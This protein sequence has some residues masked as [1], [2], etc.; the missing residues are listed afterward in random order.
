M[1]KFSILLFSILIVLGFITGCSSNDISSDIS[2]KIDKKTEDLN[3]LN[4]ENIVYNKFSG[5]NFKYYSGSGKGEI[6]ISFD[7]DVTKTNDGFKGHCTTYFDDGSGGE[8]V[9]YSYSDNELR[10]NLL[11]DSEIVGLKSE[12]IH[13]KDFIV[14]ENCL[15]RKTI[16]AKNLFV[17]T[18]VNFDILINDYMKFNSDGTMT[19]KEYKIGNSIVMKENYYSGTYTR[20]D[21]LITVDSY[22]L[23]TNHTGKWYLFIDDYGEIYTEV[24][25]LENNS[26]SETINSSIQNNNSIFQSSTIET[27]TKTV[28]VAVSP[29]YEPFIY[30]S[31]N[32]ELMG[33]DI[34]LIKFIAREMKCNISFK[35]VDFDALLLSV[36]KGTADIAISAIPAD[37]KRKELVDFTD[38]YVEETDDYEESKK[39]QYSIAVHKNSEIINE[40]NHQIG[41]LKESGKINELIL[42]YNID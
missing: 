8:R 18:S 34:D 37:E 15:V 29:D 30:Y 16:K 38:V 35:V 3:E 24:Y 31:N 42:K 26:A 32:D 10:I 33:F 5:T 20:N 39:I 21:N 28:T 11:T 27:P 22:C 14:Y 17:P 13:T 12:D 36:A 25:Q 41:K 9:S 1:K 19:I 6:T 4:D 23:E 7:N 2:S 40:L